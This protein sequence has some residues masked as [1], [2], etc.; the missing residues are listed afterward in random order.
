MRSITGKVCLPMRVCAYVSSTTTCPP[1]GIVA[2]RGEM[3]K[4]CLSMISA[5]FR[6]SSP[7]T[8][9]WCHGS[10]GTSLSC[11]NQKRK[12]TG[13]CPVLSS[14][15]RTRIGAVRCVSTPR[16][17]TSGVSPALAASKV[18]LA[19]SVSCGVTGCARRSLSATTDICRQRCDLRWYTERIS[20]TFKVGW[21]PAT[22][23]V[24]CGRRRMS[25][26]D[27]SVR[28]T[29]SWL[30]W[31]TTY[32]LYSNVPRYGSAT[33]AS[34]LTC[35]R[36]RRMP[37]FSGMKLSGG[38]SD[39]P[40]LRVAMAARRKLTSHRDELKMVMVLRASAPTST[41][42]KSTCSGSS[43]TTPM[44]PSPTT[45]QICV[46][47]T[48]PCFAVGFAALTWTGRLIS[49]RR[50]VAG[51]KRASSATSE[52]PVMTPSLG[53]SSST[54]ARRSGTSTR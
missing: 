9:S 44:T 45:R 40:S 25:S 2:R 52:H 5:S 10:L 18:K 8:G 39:A 38:A 37:V 6:S 42:P 22:V 7:L 1:A 11:G 51:V 31:L 32:T 47:T 4:S 53:V 12:S 21:P 43:A 34:T 24:Q 28:R 50:C 48:S 17:H 54:S 49:Y 3:S 33:D 41:V 16:S 46:L 26:S 36:A 23:T 27:G 30:P 19:V 29:A 14:R 13:Q 35:E 20:V 15:T